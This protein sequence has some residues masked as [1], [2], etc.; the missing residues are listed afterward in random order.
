MRGC[1]NDFQHA[2]DQPK[3]RRP[4]DGSVGRRQRNSD[5]HQHVTE[6]AR[7]AAEEQR[8]RADLPQLRQSLRR[9]H[10]QCFSAPRQRK[11]AFDLVEAQRQPFFGGVRRAA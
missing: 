10:R 6:H 4:D 3:C 7:G 1:A 9:R 5:R 8:L 11:R 2:D